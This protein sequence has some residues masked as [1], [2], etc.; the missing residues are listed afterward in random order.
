MNIKNIILSAALLACTSLSATAQ[1]SN[2][3]QQR[4]AID[5]AITIMDLY[6]IHSVIDNDEEYYDFL[7][8]FANDSVTVYNDL[9]G[10]SFDDK[11]PVIKYAK[12]LSHGLQNKKAT[13]KNIRKEDM[14]F[15]NDLWHIKLSFDKSFRYIDSC[16]TYFNSYEY[17]IISYHY[18]IYYCISI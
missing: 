16:G 1:Q 5:K 11:L 14:S 2:I 13:I 3:A 7:D 9:L 18:F 6:E 10:I 4:R 8:L 12:I 15:H 17:F